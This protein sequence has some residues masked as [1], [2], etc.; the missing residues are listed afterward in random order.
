MNSDHFLCSHTDDI[1]CQEM[2]ITISLFLAFDTMKA[3]SYI[4]VLF[5]SN[6]DSLRMF[7]MGKNVNLSLSYKS[8]F[9]TGSK[10]IR[11]IWKKNGINCQSNKERR[12]QI[13]VKTKFF[14]VSFYNVDFLKRTAHRRSNNDC[15][16]FLFFS[17]C[18]SPCLFFRK[19]A[20]SFFVFLLD[21][22]QYQY[23]NS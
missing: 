10:F 13:L 3:T 4:S 20:E 16:P 14:F 6:A 22:L 1:F 8:A 17:T 11:S 19:S 5:T 23:Q 2:K 9:V 18:E 15:L 7:V 12:H 21:W